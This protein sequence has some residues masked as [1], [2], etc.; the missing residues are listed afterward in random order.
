MKAVVLFSGGQDSCTV[1]EQ[2][3]AEYGNEALAL[4]V[5]YGQRHAIELECA[6]KYA[7]TLS[8]QHQVIEASFFGALAPS[9]LTGAGDVSADHP[10]IKGVPA[11]FVPNRN[12]FLL[13][14]AHAKA[15]AI[16][17]SVVYGGMCETDYSGYPDCRRGFI[18]ALEVALNAGSAANV[19]FVTPLMDLTKAETFALADKLGALHR[20]LEMSHT[21]YEGVREERHSWGYGCGECPACKLR[22]AGWE[23]YLA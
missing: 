19:Q 16:G 7:A 5:V 3:A 11:S 15:Q 14:L 12:A 13:T 18:D 21:C 8:V 2:A 4:S 20:V 17:A 6:A 1:L 22:K 9:A 23:E 10:F